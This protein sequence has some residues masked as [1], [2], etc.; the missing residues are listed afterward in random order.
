MELFSL[1]DDDAR[2]LF[3]TLEPSQHNLVKESNGILGDPMDFSSPCASVVDSLN[4][5][6]WS[7]W[8]FLM[9]MYLI[10]LVHNKLKQRQMITRGKRKYQL[11]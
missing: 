3:I 2:E 9:M 5:I 1:E 10:F 4:N 8:I 6:V 7:I 11:N